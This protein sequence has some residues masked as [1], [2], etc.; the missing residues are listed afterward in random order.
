MALASIVVACLLAEGVARIF[1]DAADFQQ[2]EL[3]PDE[4]LGH[5]IKPGAGGHDG[6]GFRNRDVPNQVE[7]LAIGDSMTY[8]FGTPRDTAWPHQLAALSGQGV[9]NMAMGG[10]GPLQYLHL[11]REGADKFKPKRVVVGFYFGNDLLDAYILSHAFP[12]WYDWRLT[13]DTPP[14]AT[15]G[16]AG[17]EEP[18]R[19]FGALREW[20]TQKS[21]LYSLLKA[22]VF[23]PFAVMSQRKMAKEMSP[24]DRMSWVDPAA[25]QI[26][27]VFTPRDRMWVQDLSQPSPKEGMAIAQRAFAAI[28]DETD[29]RQVELLVVLIPTRERVYCP[30][31]KSTGA[32]LPQTYAKLCE[33]EDVTKAELV[34]GFAAKGIAYVDST[35]ALE[36]EVAKHTQIYP[37]T[38]D[39][40]PTA[41]GQKVIAETVLGALMKPAAAASSKATPVAASAS[42]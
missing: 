2:V 16:P 40:H 13:T 1:V 29:K 32:S 14:G 28:K 20:L 42:R 31:L 27:T 35:P 33:I 10:Y 21:L 7:T 26:H 30:Y 41:L 11:T 18:A 34:K 6:L 5:R 36:A 8:G 24:D 23:E 39:G 22:T 15:T 9:Y 12:K 17:G 19:R 38:S 37:S 25:P 4:V 3:T